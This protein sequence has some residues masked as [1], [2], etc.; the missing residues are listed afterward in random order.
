MEASFMKPISLLIALLCVLFL[1]PV[2][3]AKEA[4]GA[5]HHA[6]GDAHAHGGHHAHR[7]HLALFTGATTN[8]EHESTDF[9]IGVDYEYRVNDTFGIGLLGEIVYAEH[10]ETIVG[11]PFFIHM[12]SSPLK[13]VLAPGV[14]MGEDHHHHKFEKFLFRGGLGYDI[15]MGDYA[16][17]PTVNADVVDGDVSLVYGIAFGIGF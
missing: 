11:V 7:N 2:I 4:S 10:K 13:F 12:K 17:T 16:I 14:I 15:H 6:A 3:Q 9:T 8:F 5:S 1:T